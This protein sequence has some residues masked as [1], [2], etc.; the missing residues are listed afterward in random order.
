[1]PNELISTAV[2]GDVVA[3]ESERLQ[4]TVT[5]ERRTSGRWAGTLTVLPPCGENNGEW[6]CL[7]HQMGFDNQ[8]LR[9]IHIARGEH[10][11]VW[12]CMHHGAEQP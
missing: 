1:M 11:M 9:D 6:F 12:I 8:L 7:T 10:K 4:R 5:G 3:F 2:A